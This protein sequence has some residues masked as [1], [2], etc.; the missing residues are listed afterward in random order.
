MDLNITDSSHLVFG[1]G[2][3]GCY[4]GGAMCDRG[5]LVKLVCRDTVKTKLQQGMQL[6]DYLGHAT[7][8]SPNMLFADLLNE[9][10]PKSSSYKFIWLT[11]KC[12]GIT[13]ALLDLT[14]YVSADT[15][16]LCCQN[17]LGSDALVKQAFPKNLV[18]RVM[19]PFNVVELKAGHFHRGSQ[20][21]LTIESSYTSDNSVTNQHLSQS[22]VE[23]LNCELLPVTQCAD[24]TALLWAKLQLNLGNSVNAL[25]DIPVKAMLEQRAYRIII[26]CLMKELLMVTEQLGI[27]LPKLTAV[28]AK[29]LP[30]VLELPDFLFKRIANKMLAID[31]NVRTS[32][33]CDV[34]QGK[35]TE[36][37]FLN[38]A[39]VEHAQLLNLDC[40]ANRLMVQMIKSQNTKVLNT[41]RLAIS[42]KD[43]LALLTRVT[44]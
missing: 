3:I 35:P 30:I 7:N 28:P 9:N 14:T 39:I 21:Q 18:L 17:G 4:L 33:W 44:A 23:L 11:V 31:P 12:T 8:L 20:G 38:G 43:M 6:T 32:M 19:V 25:A 26:A 22:L 40:P 37:D 10:N 34:S 1:A 24:M 42:A 29:W 15:V 16:I 36:I 5:L 13:Q 41:L 27:S 2:L